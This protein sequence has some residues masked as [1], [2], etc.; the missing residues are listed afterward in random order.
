MTDYYT[1]R[2]TGRLDAA[3]RFDSGEDTVVGPSCAKYFCS[4]MACRVADRA[5]QVHGGAGYMRGRACPPVTRLLRQQQ[6][7]I[8]RALSSARP[9]AREVRPS[10]SAAAACS[11]RTRSAC[12]APW[13]KLGIRPD[14][15]VGT[16]VGA[17]N[18]ALVAADPDGAAARLG[19]RWQGDS[20]RLAF[21]ETRGAG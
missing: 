5:V 16:S 11:A 18:G 13:R 7:I 9:P 17:I 6:V 14:V 19:G 8:A 20:L 15:V 21:S 2:A 4:E 1:G 12:S 3:R 10:Y